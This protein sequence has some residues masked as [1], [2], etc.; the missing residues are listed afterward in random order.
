MMLYSK[1]K[2]DSSIELKVLALS[3][4]ILDGT[5]NLVMILSSK[6]SLTTLS[7]ALLVGIALTHLVK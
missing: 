4:V 6:N 3:V 2:F 1:Q 5:P 7:V